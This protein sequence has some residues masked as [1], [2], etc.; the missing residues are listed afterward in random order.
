MT[1]PARPDRPDQPDRAGGGAVLY[2]EP[3]HRAEVRAVLL[4]LAASDDVDVESRLA[5]LEA[6]DALGATVPAGTVEPEVSARAGSLEQA[7]ELLDQG[8]ADEP[9]LTA[10]LPWSIAAGCVRRALENR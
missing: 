6:L 3:A 5:C 7:R 8:A 9:S 2:A 10:R 4:G 1:T